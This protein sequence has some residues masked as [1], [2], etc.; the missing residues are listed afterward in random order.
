[1]AE[2]PVFLYDIGSPYSWLSAERIGRLIPEA[3]WQPILLGGLFKLNGR[4]SWGFGPERDARRAEIEQRAA[5][6]GLPPIRWRPGAPTTWLTA[7]RAAIV[8][9]RVG[10]GVEF[11]LAAFRAA[12]TEARDLGDPNEV[13]ALADH[14][15]LEPDELLGA[16][17]RQDVKDKLRA[18]TERAHELGAPGVPTVLVGD[19]LFWGDDRLE[20]AARTVRAR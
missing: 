12:H 18:A 15:R 4:T 14:A 17:A 10:R 13:A 16:V 11:S 9:H 7:M 20:D 6:Y 3:Q 2:R 1:L 8:A 5:S 19:Q